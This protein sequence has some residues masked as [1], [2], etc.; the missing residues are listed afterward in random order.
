MRVPAGATLL[1]LC[2]L[3]ACTPITRTRQCKALLA[4]VNPALDSIGKLATPAGQNDPTQ[5]R[6]MAGR[7]DALAKSLAQDAPTLP[8]LKAEADDL[9]SAFAETAKT[10]VALADALSPPP[11]ATRAEVERRRIG[12]L[13]TRER[14]TAS[15]IDGMCRGR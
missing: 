13:A 12:A 2:G 7:Y 11:K 15:R 8:A 4:R 14:V 6:A 1:V 3:T 10:L 5:L 9:R